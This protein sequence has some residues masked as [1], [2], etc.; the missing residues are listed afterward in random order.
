MKKHTMRGNANR[1]AA[2]EKWISRT[3]FSFST[4]KFSGWNNRGKH[5]GD[6]DS[7]FMKCF[8]PPGP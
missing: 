2:K 5:G 1:D 8:I 6:K 4:Q 3:M 7:V